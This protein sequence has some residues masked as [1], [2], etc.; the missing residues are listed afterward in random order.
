M[1]Q[2]AA[3]DRS[4]GLSWN[5]ADTRP[6]EQFAYYREAICQA[7]MNLTPE[8]PA[9]PGFVARVETVG[10]G[11]GAVNRVSFPEHIVR[12]SAADIAVS[13]RRCYYL[14]LKLAGRCRIQQAGR[15]ISLSPGQV[16]IFDSGQRFSLLHDRG[17]ALQVASFWVPAEALDERLPSAPEAAPARVSDD[18]FVGHLIAETAQV[19]NNSALRASDTDNARLFGVL[20]DLVALS[21]SRTGRAGVI[22]SAG[23]ADATWLA[24]RR[25]V[26]RRLREP[27]LGVAAIAAAVGISERYVHKLFKR[28]GTTF[29]SYVMDRRL[30]GAARDLK[31][32]AIDGRAIGDIAFDWG[33]SDLSHFTRRFRHRFGCT[34]RDWRR[35]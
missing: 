18:P 8:P 10:L 31:D 13:S 29:A 1:Q 34:P 17:P 7:F 23:L 32:P 21:L 2:I 26:D 12:R 22:E 6:G 15:E 4:R 11:D 24:L 19:L 9:T 5:T 35:G 27:G 20:L 28:A 16:G 33:F 3:A 25:A 14:N 30:D